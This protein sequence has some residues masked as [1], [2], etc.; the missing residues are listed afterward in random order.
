MKKIM[1]VEDDKIIAEEL[2]YL[3]KNGSIMHEFVNGSIAV[4]KGDE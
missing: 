4:Q 1:I 3:L 2:M